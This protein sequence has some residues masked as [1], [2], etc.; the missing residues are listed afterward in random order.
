LYRIK[1]MRRKAAVAA[2]AVLL[3]PVAL[4]LAAAADDAAARRC[5]I[6]CGHAIGAMAGAACCPMADAPGEGPVLKNCSR[7]ADSVAAPLAPGPMLL[8]RGVRLAVP[9]G[10]QTHFSAG[11]AAVHSAFL[12]VPEKVPLLAG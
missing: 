5:A 6:A 2:L 1:P 11:N 10:V 9:D 12:R 4:R 3:A 7:G 8:W